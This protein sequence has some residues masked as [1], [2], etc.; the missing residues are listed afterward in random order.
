MDLVVAA[1]DHLSDQATGDRGEKIVAVIVLHPMIAAARLAQMGLGII[2]FLGAAA[3]IHEGLTAGPWVI[4]E[5]HVALIGGGLPV[6]P[7]IVLVIAI[8]LGIV[9]TRVRAMIAPGM[10]PVAMI[11]SGIGMHVGVHVGG[12]GGDRLLI[13]LGLLSLM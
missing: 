8:V 11:T 7:A 1:E 12:L 10:T 2:Y 4:T 3:V 9:P 5:L 6:M 13:L